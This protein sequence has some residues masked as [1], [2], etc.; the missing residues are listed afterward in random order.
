MT[1]YQGPFWFL[2]AAIA[3]GLLIALGMFLSKK[4]KVT[5]WYDWV[6][7]G[8]A[9]LMGFFAVQNYF[10]SI[11]EFEEEAASMFLVIVGIP[12]LLLLGVAA[13]LIVRR[14]AAV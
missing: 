14:K 11:S 12:A 4:G 13:A 9:L 10:G 5:K 8:I 6:I 7:I 1:V 3:I 2:M